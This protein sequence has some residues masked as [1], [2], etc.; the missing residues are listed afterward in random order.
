MISDIYGTNTGSSK[1]IDC[2][3]AYIQ[4]LDILYDPDSGITTGI[5]ATCSDGTAH[6]VS[7]GPGKKYKLNSGF[8][9]RDLSLYDSDSGPG[10]MGIRLNGDDNPYPPIK[11][12]YGGHTY[13]KKNFSCPGKAVVNKLNLGTGGNQV[14]SIQAECAEIS[15][16]YTMAALIIVFNVILLIIAV[17][18]VALVLRAKSK[19]AKKVK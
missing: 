3:N 7:S 4:E 6:T 1:S 17:I 14:H 12:S 9:I 15:G 5:D 16:R 10:F 11:P 2:G 8:G 19:K 18:V 13:V